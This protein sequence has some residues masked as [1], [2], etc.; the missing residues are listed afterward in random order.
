[1]RHR[2]GL[3]RAGDPEQHLLA[4]AA[5]DAFDQFVDRLRL[6]AGRLEF[7]RNPEFPPDISLRAFGDEE[8][9][10]GR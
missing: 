9:Q 8:R 6:V 3:A 5:L 7:R 10:H 4:L 1:M 2:E